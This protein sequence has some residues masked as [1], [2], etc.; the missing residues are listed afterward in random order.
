ME[1]Q[2]RKVFTLERGVTEK[3]H[4]EEL[5]ECQWCHTSWSENSENCENLLSYVL[6]IWESFVFCFLQVYQFAFLYFETLLF[7]A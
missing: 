4:K 5:L 3:R 6:I 2:V 1:L 7:G